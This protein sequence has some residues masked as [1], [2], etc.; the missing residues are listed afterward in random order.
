MEIAGAALGTVIARAVETMI[1]GGY[2]FF[3]ENKVA[4]RS[5][6]IF[7]KCGDAV[8]KY[9]RYS[10]PVM[11]S[12]ALLAF[13]NS[14]VSIIIGHMGTAFVTANA[15]IAMI[16]RLCTVFSAGMGQ[17]AHTVIGNRIGEGKKE[18]AFYEAITLLSLSVI[19]GVI[20]AVVMRIIGPF[21][22]SFYDISAETYEIAMLMMDA[23]ALMI[24]FQAM[25]GTI[26]KGIL[27]GGGDTKFV[28]FIDAGFL[29]LVSVPLGYYTG[30]IMH[31]NAFIVMLCLRID[32]MIKTVIGSWRIISNKWIR[33]IDL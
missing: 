31:L 28:M 8:G 17:A 7:M 24:I 33:E 15:I 9:F 10:I 6:D 14:A 18:V 3:I 1:I 2:F 5:K 26:T 19:I 20:T 12:D 11:A 22:L 13:G 16:Q 27:R 32:W 25:Q 23:T 30:L 4:Y 29:W 21:F